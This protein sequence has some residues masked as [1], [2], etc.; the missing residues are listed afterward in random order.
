MFHFRGSVF[1]FNELVMT[2]YEC[3]TTAVSQP[4][5]KV[6]IMFNAK[7]RLGLSPEAIVKL[8]GTMT[9]SEGRVYKL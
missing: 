9:D 3:E 4:R 5:A 7:R 6:N 8:K 1:V 2:G